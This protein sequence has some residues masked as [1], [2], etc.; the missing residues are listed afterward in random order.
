MYAR[1]ATSPNLL[2]IE[3]RFIRCRNF[4]RRSCKKSFFSK[5]ISYSSTLSRFGPLEL[6]PT[7]DLSAFPRSLNVSS[8]RFV[9]RYS[10]R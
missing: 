2:R 7:A 1:L 6:V 5:H 4:L 9:L 8:P 10:L 3:P